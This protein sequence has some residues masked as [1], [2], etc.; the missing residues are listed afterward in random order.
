M[1]KQ[2]AG[3][4]NLTKKKRFHWEKQNGICPG[5]D[6]PMDPNLGDNLDL[7]HIVPKAEG[8]SSSS[9]NLVLLHEHCHYVTHASVSAASRA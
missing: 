2:K 4:Y 6:S 8:G 7:H 3:E 9:R 5:C 1:K